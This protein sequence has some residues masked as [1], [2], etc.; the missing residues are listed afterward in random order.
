MNIDAGSLIAKANAYKSVL[1]NTIQ[2]RQMWQ[3]QLKNEIKQSLE[4]ILKQIDIRG[5]VKIQDKLENLESIMLDL[6]KTSSGISENIENSGVKRTMV[7][8]NGAL[9]YQQ[10]FNG[11][12]MVMIVSPYIEGYG[13]PKAPRTLEILRPGELK[14][15]FLLRH[16]ETL[17]KEIIDWEDYDDDEPNK[18]T[19]GFQPIGFNQGEIEE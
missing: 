12:I 2:Y 9:I 14:P 7:K 3:S 10:L 18:A 16:V 6:G 8:N 1:E 17:L 15:P 5:E 11:K 13:E 19:I 4:D